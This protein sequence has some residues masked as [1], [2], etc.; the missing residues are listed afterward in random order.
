MPG[1]ALGTQEVGATRISRQS[2][3]EGGM[4]VSPAHQPPLPQKI[5]LV[6]VRGSPVPIVWPKDF[7]NEKFKLLHRESNP[8]HSGL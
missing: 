4:V 1:Q 8:Q 5:L 2:A 3:H 6:L 7:V